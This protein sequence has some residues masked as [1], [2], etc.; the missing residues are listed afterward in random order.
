MPTATINQA[1]LAAMGSDVALLQTA[2]GVPMINLW[3]KVLVPGLEKY[4]SIKNTLV[5]FLAYRTDLEVEEVIQAV[6]STWQKNTEVT[7]GVG[8]VKI[9]G[10]WIRTARDEFKKYMGWTRKYIRENNSS[11]IAA[12]LNAEL[13]GLTAQKFQEVLST[14]YNKGEK[15]VLDR[16]THEALKIACLVDGVGT[17]VPPP[18][19][20]TTFLANHS[21]FTYEATGESAWSVVA[22]REA[23]LKA[24]V[25][26]VREHGFFKNLVLMCN[27]G[28][29]DSIAA[30]PSFR[31]FVSVSPFGQSED[32][33]LRGSDTQATMATFRE[34][35]GM[36]RVI[37]TL[38]FATVMESDLLPNKYVSAFSYQGQNSPDNPVQWFEGPVTS[39]SEN[40]FPFY[41]TILETEFGASIRK[42]LN[43]AH[44]FV[45]A[46]ISAYANPTLVGL[47]TQAGDYLA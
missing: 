20:G 37:G 27:P 44:M 1:A 8:Q 23:A 15:V 2:D 25:K 18:V 17:M 3:T 34:F 36:F 41:E 40:P 10:Y 21:H 29:S 31:G 11:A 7:K 42:R 39:F 9:G 32:A 46:G 47:E 45:D 33:A 26:L 19:G 30:C 22:T 6:G 28:M 4:N 38:P 5:D 35:A 16:R 13:K 14:F 12:H 24:L 43:G